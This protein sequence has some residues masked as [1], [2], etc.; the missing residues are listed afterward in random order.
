MPSPDDAI[1]FR[2]RQPM[3]VD[4]AFAI[5]EEVARQGPGV[6]ARQIVEA[7]DMPRSTVYRI[8]KHLVQEEY[9]VRS[10][11][12]SGFALGARL[13]MLSVPARQGVRTGAGEKSES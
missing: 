3:A 13:E 7:V 10:P 8:L 2:G 1:E 11:D 12:L 9:L 5:L 4:H 6:G